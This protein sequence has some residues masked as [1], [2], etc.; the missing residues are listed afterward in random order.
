MRCGISGRRSKLESASNGYEGLLKVG[1]FRPDLLVLDIRMPGLDGSEVC[2][3]VKAN[4]A[5]RTT[6][7]LVITAFVDEGGRA[8]SLPSGRGRIPQKASPDWT[9]SQRSRDVIRARPPRRVRRR[10]VR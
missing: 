2:R 1:N 3:R 5:T 7:I 6:R 9:T 4:S 8:G 10:S